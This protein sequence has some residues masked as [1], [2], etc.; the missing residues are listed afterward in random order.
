MEKAESYGNECYEIVLGDLFSSAF[1][2]V[3]SSIIGIPSEKDIKIKERCEEILKYIS[4]FSPAYNL[5]KN[6]KENAEININQSVRRYQSLEEE[7]S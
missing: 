2:G 4:D 1:C 6:L 3:R 5:Y 7:Y